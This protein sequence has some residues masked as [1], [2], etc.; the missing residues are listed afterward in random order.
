VNK[1]GDRSPPKEKKMFNW[2][3]YVMIRAWIVYGAAFIAFNVA[4][5]TLI[6]SLF[7]T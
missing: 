7:D 4:M 6:M 5:V 2:H 1:T 3:K